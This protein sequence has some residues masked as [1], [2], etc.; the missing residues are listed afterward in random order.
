MLGAAQA[1]AWVEEGT[2]T[3]PAYAR[4]NT[5][6]TRH[7]YGLGPGRAHLSQRPGWQQPRPPIATPP[8]LE[9]NRRAACGLAEPAN[10]C[11]SVRGGTTHCPRTGS[12]R[13]EVYNRTEPDHSWVMCALVAACMQTGEGQARVDTVPGE[14]NMEDLMGVT[15]MRA[16]AGTLAT[17]SACVLWNGKLVGG[18]TQCV[19]RAALPQNC[20]IQ[21]RRTETPLPSQALPRMRERYPLHPSVHVPPRQPPLKGVVPANNTESGGSSAGRVSEGE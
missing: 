14:A 5:L 13:R 4:G 17:D 6:R 7:H 19:L 8:P 1:V 11:A 18:R 10:A 9:N 12:W 16:G 15:D 3:R 21:M 20:P 2:G